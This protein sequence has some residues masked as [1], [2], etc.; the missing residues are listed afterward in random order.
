[1]M[2]L[3]VHTACP[4]NAEGTRAKVAARARTEYMTVEMT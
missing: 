2:I 1:M 4:A 3:T